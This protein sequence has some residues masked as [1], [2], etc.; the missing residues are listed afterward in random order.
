MLIFN[1]F[2]NDFWG[3]LLKR[4]DFYKFYCFIIVLIFCWNFFVGGFNLIGYYFI[5]VVL[6]SIVLVLFFY[7][8][9]RI[10]NGNVGFNIKLF[11]FFCGMFFVFYLIYIEVVVNV[12]GCVEI[13]C[14]LFYFLVLLLYIN[15]F[16]DG[17]IEDSS[18]RFVKYLRVWFVLCIFWC[19]L[20]FF[21][22]E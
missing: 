12:V 10:L 17:I 3:I 14:V 15:C 22:K 2:L 21:S 6:Y 4:N 18:K 16:F 1:L 11:F 13:F 5:N 9:I 8:C 20:F 7:I 19:V